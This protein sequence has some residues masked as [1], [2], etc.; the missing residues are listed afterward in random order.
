MLGFNS[1]ILQVIV[2]HSNSLHFKTTISWQKLIFLE[3][4]FKRHN[5]TSVY[6]KL[7]KHASLANITTLQSNMQFSLLQNPAEHVG[8]CVFWH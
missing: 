8:I 3:P 1:N 7:P 6:F 4:Y 2:H 5:N